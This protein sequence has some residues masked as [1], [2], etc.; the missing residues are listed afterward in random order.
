MPAERWAD[1][2]VERWTIAMGN[3]STNKGWLLIAGLTVW[4]CDRGNEVQKEVED[5]KQAQHESPKVASDLQQQLDE[6][7]AEVVKLEEKVALAKQGVTDDVEKEKGELKSAVKDNERAVREEIDQAQTA[8]R[9]QQDQGAQAARQL[10]QTERA[11]RVEAEVKTETHV[12]PGQAETEVRKEQEVVPV[13]NT[14]VVERR[15]VEPTAGDAG[16]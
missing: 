6:K 15:K 5:L 12:V 13:T 2:D 16:R 14:R 3:G 4:G 1:V 8:A 9:R 10:E 7:K 11:K